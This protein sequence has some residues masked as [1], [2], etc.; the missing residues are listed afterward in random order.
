MR[1]A[2][3]FCRLREMVGGGVLPGPYRLVGR[4]PVIPQTRRSTPS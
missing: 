4:I 1:L 3:A 2:D